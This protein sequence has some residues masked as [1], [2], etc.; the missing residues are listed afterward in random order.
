[1]N[2]VPVVI[3]HGYV[4]ATHKFSFAKSDIAQVTIF[5]EQRERTGT[6]GHLGRQRLL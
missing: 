4:D 1:M 6:E 3:A 2:R 5:V